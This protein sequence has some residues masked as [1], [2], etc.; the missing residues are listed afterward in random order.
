[1][2]PLQSPYLYRIIHQH[3][4]PSINTPLRRLAHSPDVTESANQ[5]TKVG[6]CRL[7]VTAAIKMCTHRG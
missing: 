2:M 7:G 3:L 5:Q 6:G 4:N 1:M